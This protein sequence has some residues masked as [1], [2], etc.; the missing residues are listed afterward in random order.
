MCQVMLILII[1]LLGLGIV[2]AVSSKLF[3]KDDGSGIVH[4]HGDCATCSGDNGAC[5]HDCMLEAAVKEADYYDDEELDGYRGRP[6]DGYTDDEA[7][8]FREV[9]LTMR[10]DEVAGWA[11]SLTLRGILPPDQIKDEMIM[12]MNEH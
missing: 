4:P 6:S 12:L 1:I 10:Q 8:L 9:M 3:V 11:R 7:E 2:V 5:M